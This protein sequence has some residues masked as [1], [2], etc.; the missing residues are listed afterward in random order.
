MKECLQ[1]SVLVLEMGVCFSSNI[2]NEKYSFSTF[3]ASLPKDYNSM[4]SQ[5]DK[6]HT[7]FAGISFL[8]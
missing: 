2:Q 1:L 5:Q 3:T 4:G 8:L 6:R 7:I